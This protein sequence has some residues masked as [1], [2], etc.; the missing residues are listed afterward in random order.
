[1]SIA[2]KNTAL[3]YALEDSSANHSA[4]LY[5]KNIFIFDKNRCVGCDACVIACVNE[6]GFQSPETWR[7]VSKSNP[8]HFPG[9]PLFHLSMACNHCDYAPCEDSCPAQAFYFDKKTGA[10][11][12]DSESCIGCKYC[13]WTCPYD[14][15]KF[16]PVQG[17][18]EKCTFCNHRIEKGLKPS[19]ANLCPTGALD[20]AFIDLS[21]DEA[22]ESSPVSVK[23]GSSLK[24]IELQNPSSPKLDI[25]L[26][27]APIKS[28][29]DAPSPKSISAKKEWSL[30]VFSIISSIM[31]G[32]Y[33][34]KTT[35]S[36][37]IYLKWVII[38]SGASAATISLLHL[39]KKG[40]AW[41]AITN[42]EKSW[43]SREILFFVFFFV[44]LIIDFFF[45]DI[46]DIVPVINGVLLL[47][48]VDML[49]KPIMWKWRMKI[50]SAQ[51]L[52]IAIGI[53]LAISQYFYL[54]LFL[55]L[56]RITLYFL[57]KIR[58]SKNQLII[59]IT[60][61]G[62]LILGSCFVF[63]SPYLWIG[64]GLMVLS[65][66]VDRIEFYN[67]L[68]VPACGISSVGFRSSKPSNRD[69]VY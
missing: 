42:I 1:M 6:N 23:V 59:S 62:L 39:G 56:A 18:I 45:W 46:P 25:K 20:F 48:S 60:R 26:F 44:S 57:R 8:Q 15:P 53:W 49:Y 4:P 66:F 32:L 22:L 30:V 52:F 67:E 12:H 24:I 65:D 21:P 43:L 61:T 29:P 54:F 64:I 35:I 37:S 34:A 27:D 9:L 38:G 50:H 68:R 7:S 47:S 58:N 2:D 28:S 13:T 5:K 33:L 69:T 41:R 10:I 40:R 63:L 14:A 17:I 31:L 3:D 55:S 11:L 51:S 16:N 36:S 19:C